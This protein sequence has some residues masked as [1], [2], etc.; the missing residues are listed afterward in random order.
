MPAD[1]G[2]LD[3][4]QGPPPAGASGYRGPSGRSGFA[5]RIPAVITSRAELIDALSVASSIEHAIL[6]QYLFTA[7][8]LRN[9]TD[10]P[11]TGA[12]DLMLRRWA[13]TMLK[14]SHEEMIH[15]GIVTNLLNVLGAGPVMHRPN[16]PQAISPGSPYMLSLTRW[17]DHTLWRYVRMELPQ[18]EAIPQEPLR[19]RGADRIDPTGPHAPIEFDYLGELYDIIRGG[20]QTLG[21]GVFLVPEG[22]DQDTRWGLTV[23]PI[24]AV[25]DLPSAL[26]ALDLVVEQGEGAPG[27]R[28]DS[29]FERFQALRR[30]LA[31][32]PPGFVAVRTI[33]D[34]PRTWAQHQDSPYPGTYLENDTTR[35]VAVVANEAYRILM[36]LMLQMFSYDGGPADGPAMLTDRTLVKAASR[37]MMSS[38]IRPIAEILT[39]MPVGDDPRDGVAGIPFEVFEEIRL[40]PRHE[41]RFTLIEEALAELAAH[42]RQ[43]AADTGLRRL[44]TLA[45]HAGWIRRNLTKGVS[46]VG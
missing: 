8:S 25:V 31:D 44:D 30:E 3:L 42:C 20:F 23:R 28:A 37:Q 6:L 24:P 33:V 22:V 4:R 43:L 13:Q 18:G 16:F 39:G 36:L 12:Q 26:S 7:W 27:N 5:R 19:S 1:A 35:S 21:E 17:D 38:F 34:N 41:P 46:G 10:G 29:H 9:R 15:L 11:L 2:A 40:P 32:L 45:E 14:V